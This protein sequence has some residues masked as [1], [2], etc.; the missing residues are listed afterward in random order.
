MPG[1]STARGVDS[2]NTR[3]LNETRKGRRERPSAPRSCRDRAEGATA[4]PAERR[5]AGAT[6]PASS[7]CSSVPPLPQGS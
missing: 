6:G 5:V 4:S 1:E 3:S 7:A 2:A